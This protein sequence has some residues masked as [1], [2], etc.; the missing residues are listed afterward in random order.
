MRVTQTQTLPQVVFSSNALRVMILYYDRKY[1][2]SHLIDYREFRKLVQQVENH[3][4]VENEQQIRK[5]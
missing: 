4:L 2:V 3:N 1:I 5:L